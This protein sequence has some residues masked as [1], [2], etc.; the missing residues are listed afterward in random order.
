MKTKG[1]KAPARSGFLLAAL[2]PFAVRGEKF[3]ERTRNA[4]DAQE[5][6]RISREVDLLGSLSQAP[7]HLLSGLDVF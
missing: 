2:V 4:D 3:D 5:L 7:G 6:R 1:T